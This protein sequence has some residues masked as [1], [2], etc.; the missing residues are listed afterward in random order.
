MKLGNPERLNRLYNDIKG[1]DWFMAMIDIEEFIQTKEKVYQD[2]EDRKSW[3]AKVVKNIA[4]A[5][6]FSSDRTISDYNQDIWHLE[7]H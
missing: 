4:Q 5:G 1:K 2:Y 6:Y 7:E 3:L